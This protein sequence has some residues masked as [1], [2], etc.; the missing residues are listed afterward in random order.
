MMKDNAETMI[1]VE[2]LSASLQHFEWLDYVVFIFVLLICIG[3]GI[4][5][6]FMEKYHQKRRKKKGSEALNYLVGGRKMQVIPIA[7]S[8]IASWVSG[9][10]LLGTS[11]EIYVY[12]IQ[13]AFMLVS[14]IMSGIVAWYIYLPVMVELQLTSS[15][16]YLELR[17]NKSVRVFGSVLYVI[18]S[19]LYLPIVIYIPA[20]AFNQIAGINIQVIS[21]IVCSV[22]IF[23]TCVGGIKAVVWTDVLQTF[24][25]MGAIII[26][27]V[28][29][30][31]ELG[32]VGTV[33]QRNL[34]ANRIEFP[35][36]TLDPTIRYSVIS[37][38][39]AGFLYWIQ[40]STGNQSMLQRYLSLPTLRA[41]RKALIYFF[42]GLIVMVLCFVYNGLLLYAKY[43]DCDPLT[44]KLAKAKDQMVPLIIMDV[45]GNVPGMPGFFIS[46]VFAA[47]LSSLS[48][49]L[50][51]L[52]A[53]I[54]EDFFKP[55]IKHPITERQTAVVMRT[56]VVV[57]GSVCVAL[58]LVVEK[59]GAV[60][61]LTA[62]F[63][64]ITYGPTCGIFL[65]GLLMPWVNGKSALTG[66]I[67]AF[68]ITGIISIRSQLLEASG[69]KAPEKPV[70][71]DGCTYN[72]TSSVVSS[73]TNSSLIDD[74]GNN[75]EDDLRPLAYVF[76]MAIGTAIT[77]IVAL[78]SS[79]A[80]GS[81]DPRDVDERLIAPFVRKFIKP[82][83]YLSVQPDVKEHENVIHAF[84]LQQTERNSGSNG[85]EENHVP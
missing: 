45:L 49:A 52:T 41:A 40:S 8:L 46:G 83:K 69:I 65:I 50:N 55:Y 23:Y 2:E 20:L 39:G 5:F 31:A 38:Y 62:T 60:I 64:A 1:T 59:L 67:S 18:F 56:I 63:N 78:L 82:R 26:L 81:L 48:T 22:C 12:G 66:G 35:D 3:I 36:V 68:I 13:Y 77:I 19:I 74:I 79:F 76:P 72:F 7:L 29:G 15:Y 70:R 42:F 33:W 6:G 44:T 80:Y 34:D 10:S 84:E 53:I 21:L 11:T 71:T 58:V 73:I 47:A 9:I 32:G 4:Y 37:V 57:F 14:L 43:Y 30:T 61:Q 85:K 75:P 17:F 51:C 54:L 27:L 28:V 24:I 16:E 25:M